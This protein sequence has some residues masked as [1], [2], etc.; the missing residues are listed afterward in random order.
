MAR[1]QVRR[2]DLTIGIDFGTS[3]TKVCVREELDLAQDVE[4][5]PIELEGDGN[6][7]CPSLVVIEE[8]Q[9]FFGG[10]AADLLASGRGKGFPH[11]KVCLACQAESGC[12]LSGCLALQ[13]D[14][15]SCHGRFQC[16]TEVTAEEL[17]VCFLAW[18]MA[19]V[20]RNLPDVFAG[21]ET[22]S[23]TYNIGVPAAHLDSTNPLE[24]LYRRLTQSAER[25]SSRFGQGIELREALTLVRAALEVPVLDESESVVQLCP[26]AEA[27]MISYLVSP[28]TPEGPYGIVDIGAWTTDMSVFR[29]TDLISDA[30]AGRSVEYYAASS[31]RVALN[32]VDE[33]VTRT[34]R[35][36][37]AQDV[38]T[39][40]PPIDMETVRFWREASRGPN[41][42]VVFEKAPSLVDFF[43]RTCESVGEEILAAFRRVLAEVKTKAPLTHF[44]EEQRAQV[45]RADTYKSVPPRRKLYMYVVGGGALEPALWEPISTS[46]LVAAIEPLPPLYLSRKLTG[47]LEGRFSVALGLAYPR[48]LWPA[49]FGPSATPPFP[50]QRV[51]YRPDLDDM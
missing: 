22:I 4:V 13:D 7:L 24:R 41:A 9:L 17:G 6:L 35:E 45:G 11:L 30:H 34:L 43:N 1:A 3:T 2:L 38:A 50:R 20:P 31:E 28:A 33:S 16:S 8:N 49:S 25:I 47:D 23:V 15:G 32:T 12:P 51:R 26:E 10:A 21:F 14:R 19:S 18:V 48:M 39:D 27:A 5:H 42:Q 29:L 36:S 44:V 46:A 40:E 37:E